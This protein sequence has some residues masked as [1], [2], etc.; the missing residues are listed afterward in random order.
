MTK[1]QTQIAIARFV[2][3]ALAPA[4]QFVVGALAPAVRSRGFSP[5]SALFFGFLL[6]FAGGIVPG[7]M[8]QPAIAQ[9]IQ[10]EDVA[11]RLYQLLPDLPQRNQYISVE[12]GEIAPDNSLATRLIRYHLYVKNRP[13]LYRFDW[14]I[15]LADYLGINDPMPANA[16]PGATTLQENPVEADIA[17]IRSLNRKQREELV[18]ALVSIFNP[19][20]ASQP[21]SSTSQPSPQPTNSTPGLFRLPSPG[22]ADLLRPISSPN[23]SR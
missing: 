6:A 11:P 12:T 8:E 19:E 16:Y 4:V 20:A 14:K 3:G 5:C 9:F 1:K 13:F 17:A 7:K 22:D 18:D 21:D 15:T 10:P 23:F 2:V